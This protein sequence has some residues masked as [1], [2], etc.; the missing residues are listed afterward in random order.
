MG[1]VRVEKRRGNFRFFSSFLLEGGKMCVYGESH[2]RVPLV[3]F[4]TGKR[5]RHREREKVGF[6]G[7]Y[8]GGRRESFLM[9]F[10]CSNSRFL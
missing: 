5:D 2:C 4:L 7:I 6:C 8:F 10:Q 9:D 3:M 1:I